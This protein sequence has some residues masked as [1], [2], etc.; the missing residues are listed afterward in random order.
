[1]NP[2]FHAAPA[3]PGR[4]V[5]VAGVPMHGLVQ[6]RGGP[7]VVLESGLGGSAL[8]WEQVA[9]GLAAQT[10]VVRR[11]RPGLGWS[12]HAKRD[13]SALSAAA[14]LNTLLGALGVPP[15]YVLVGHSLGGLHVRAYAA[16]HP[17]QVAG[18]VLVDATHEHFFLR[19]PAARRAIAVQRKV[20]AVLAV[21]GRVANGVPHALMRRLA[22]STTAPHARAEVER[23]LATARALDRAQRW[24]FQSF[25]DETAA[26]TTSCRQI[27]ELRNGPH[28]P[29]VP[30]RV[31]TQ[32]RPARNRREQALIDRIRTHYHADLAG[33]SLNSRHLIAER[34]GHLVPFDQPEIIVE[35][36]RDILHVLRG[37]E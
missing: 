3:A 27:D 5:E 19:E 35:A 13:R 7:A 8:E 1:M 28:F 26:V 23:V 17:E 36:V 18:V 14:E 9:Q 16:L 31:I 22:L 24:Y 11:D 4:L 15:P 29:P 21:L 33:L 2:P 30:L 20:G 12:Q 37:R 34:S 10:T 6:G 25:S 32:G